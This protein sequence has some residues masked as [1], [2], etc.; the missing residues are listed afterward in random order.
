MSA[1][2]TVGYNG[3]PSST[4]AVH[5]AAAEAAIRGA[6]LHIVSC[7]E[8]P[9]MGEAVIGWPATE[10]VAALLAATESSLEG[11][12]RIVAAD[13]HALVIT[14][15]ASAGPAAIVLL[16]DMTA[17]GLVVVGAGSR[18]GAAATW[19]GSTPRDVVRHSPCPVVVVRGAASRG[20]PDRVLVGVD[21]SATSDKALL[22]AADE[23]DRHGVDLVIV[24]GWRYPYL[25]AEHES[26]VARDLMQI[27]AATILER[28]EELAR[29]RCGV[30]VH[31]MLVEQEPVTALLDSAADGDLLVVGS[32]GR[33]AV[34]SSLFG[35]TANS[36]LDRSVL[37]VAVV[38]GSSDEEES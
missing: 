26:S 2:V 19:L 17:D 33:G 32:R 31:G 34:K 8:I 13:H 9:V 1:Q 14:T 7:Y 25:I 29:E 21:G 27:D 23:A 15:E 16:N 11:I 24:H 10:A 12:R 6:R 22:W 5:W 18:G 3:T 35:S 30:D 38:R 20:R 4:E 36:L 37:P 28:A